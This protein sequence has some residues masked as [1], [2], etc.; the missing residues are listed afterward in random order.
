[1]VFCFTITPLFSIWGFCIMSNK[2]NQNKLS[3]FGGQFKKK[4]LQASIFVT[5]LWWMSGFV[6]QPKPSWWQAVF[7]AL[8]VI[9]MGFVW[10]E[11]RRISK[12]LT[13]T[14]KD[15]AN[16]MLDNVALHAGIPNTNHSVR[17]FESLDDARKFGWVF[18]DQIGTYNNLPLYRTAKK[19]GDDVFFVFDGLSRNKFPNVISD[20]FVAFGRMMYKKEVKAVDPD[21]L[22][23][24]PIGP[25][26]SVGDVEKSSENSS[27]LA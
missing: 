13:E 23:G 14:D 12:E 19:E 17:N 4:A 15:V 5:L 26:L 11:L 3:V 16:A 27:A 7:M 10:L 20:A 1:M 25:P 8:N 2:Q 21:N 6:W 18:G 9:S 22:E 24:A